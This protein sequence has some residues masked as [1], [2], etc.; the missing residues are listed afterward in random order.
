MI[1]KLIEIIKNFQEQ[2]ENFLTMVSSIMS[3]PIAIIIPLFIFIVIVKMFFQWLFNKIPAD[4][5]QNTYDKKDLEKEIKELENQLEIEQL[6][7][8]QIKGNLTKELKIKK[9]ELSSILEEEKEEEK[10][11]SKKGKNKKNE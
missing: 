11:K 8:E 5:E 10:E 2:V 9:I 4:T 7:Y 1:E 3:W 6:K